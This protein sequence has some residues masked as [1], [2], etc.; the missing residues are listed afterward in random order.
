MLGKKLVMIGFITALT[1]SSLSVCEA[2]AVYGAGDYYDQYEESRIPEAENVSGISAVAEEMETDGADD[3]ASDGEPEEISVQVDEPV[4]GDGGDEEAL[5]VE[6]GP[7]QTEAP[8]ESD[9][10]EPEAE[11]E[12][13]EEAALEEPAPEEAET[14]GQE[15]ESV[16]AEYLVT[17][18][19]SDLVMQKGAILTEE[20]LEEGSTV[21]EVVQT[22]GDS[23]GEDSQAADIEDV[24]AV[25][26]E[27]EIIDGGVEDLQAGLAYT[28]N[29]R[30]MDALLRAAIEGREE[31]VNLSS[32]HIKA[33]NVGTYYARLINDNA[34]Y[35]Y[36]DTEYKYA[37][38][39]GY[40]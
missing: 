4:P 6:T 12:P 27:E 11:A 40:V 5:P 39:S 1:G 25:D 7:E 24:Y 36:V 23:Q 3:A 31:S 15:A 17:E 14:D 22:E 13:V 32:C 21:L 33:V 28:E 16:P 8:E 9:A 2:G 26:P 29:V 18:D 10:A 19:V 38:I 20:S 34:R 30:Q 35:F 37:S